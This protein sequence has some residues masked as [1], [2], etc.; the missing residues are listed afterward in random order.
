M[1]DIPPTERHLLSLAL[2]PIEQRPDALARSLTWR[3][4]PSSGVPVALSA[5]VTAVLPVEAGL[6]AVLA[7]GF[8]DRSE[9]S[10]SLQITVDRIKCDPLAAWTW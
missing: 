9:R 4:R 3:A 6:T 2:P 7:G 1:I 10:S 5:G 8:G